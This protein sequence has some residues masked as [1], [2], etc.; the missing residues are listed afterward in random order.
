MTPWDY[1]ERYLPIMVP[2]PDGDIPVSVRRYHIGAPTA[3]KDLTYTGVQDHIN[4]QR[5]K[6]PGYRL[7][8]QVN[9]NPISIGAW[10][11]VRESLL[12]PFWGKG[13]PEDC[14]IVLQVAL[15]VLGIKPDRLQ[16]WA[17][18]NLGLDC[19]GFVGNYL[20]HDVMGNP[21]N[22]YPG[23]G[24]PGPN[25]TID[26]IFQWVAG[27]TEKDAIADVSEITLNDKYVIARVAANGHVVAGGP[28]SV[29]GH[30]AITEP[31][32]LLRGLEFVEAMGL[33]PGPAG[34]SA[35]ERCAVRTVESG[36]FPA[37]NSDGV[38]RNWM[39][40][41]RKHETLPKVFW[42]DRDR[43]HLVEPVKLAPVRKAASAS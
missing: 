28:N 16:A 24:P 31:G 38:G 1:A 42:I 4:A 14:Q 32:Q 15:N 40:I 34:L 26:Q 36:G 30:I 12:Q 2:S 43:L 6:T 3:A 19:N 21:W 10:T 41:L 9:D 20:W 8:L 37:G 11:D 18:A 35:G 5:K 33:D 17:D 25:A 39:T 7:T 13:S 29:A 23:E 22:A 27:G